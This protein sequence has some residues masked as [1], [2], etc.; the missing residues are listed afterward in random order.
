MGYEASQ[1]TVYTRVSRHNSEQDREDDRAVEELKTLIEQAIA[2]D[3][4]LKRIC[5]LGVSG[6]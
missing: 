4:R 5:L 3:E 1:L 6:P 2:S